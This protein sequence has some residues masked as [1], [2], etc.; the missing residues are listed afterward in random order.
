MKTMSWSRYHALS[1]SFM[2]MRAH[3][4][5]S[6][7]KRTRC[8]GHAV[9]SSVVPGVLVVRARSCGSRQ[10]GRGLGRFL[11]RT[12]RSI[13]TFFRTGVLPRKTDI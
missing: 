7:V 6:G 1:W 5:G 11:A 10:D 2:R 3:L 9:A 13:I 8:T 12:F 4:R